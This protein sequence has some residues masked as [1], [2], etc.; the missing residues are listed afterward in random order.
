VVST[1][2]QQGPAFPQE[3]THNPPKLDVHEKSAGTAKWALCA[4]VAFGVLIPT[5]GFCR[6]QI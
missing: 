2:G 6:E 3:A 4:P 5:P 1:T